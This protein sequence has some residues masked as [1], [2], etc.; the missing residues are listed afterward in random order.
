MTTVVTR[1][2]WKA[3]AAAVGLSLEA[4]AHLTDTKYPSVYAYSVG[5]RR[6]PDAW[7]AAVA[8]LIRARENAA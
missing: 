1:E 5:R 7:L 2:T 6:A 3:Q 4:I 8:A